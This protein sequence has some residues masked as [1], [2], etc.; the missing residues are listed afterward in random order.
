[1]SLPITPVNNLP[2]TLCYIAMNKM[3]INKKHFIY[4]I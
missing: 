1:M 3:N 4:K 2:N